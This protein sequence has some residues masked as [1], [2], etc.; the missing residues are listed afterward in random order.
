MGIKLNDNKEEKKPDAAE[1]KV[2]PAPVD[3]PDH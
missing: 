3:K 2:D 1:P